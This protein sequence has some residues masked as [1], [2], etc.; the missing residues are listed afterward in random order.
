MGMT[1]E[2][3]DLEISKREKLIKDIDAATKAA[4]KAG[5]P[6]VNDEAATDRYIDLFTHLALLRDL[7]EIYFIDDEEGDSTEAIRDYAHSVGFRSTQGEVTTRDNLRIDLDYFPHAV[8]NSKICRE[9]KTVDQLKEILEGKE[10]ISKPKK[11][12][13]K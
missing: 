5:I 12:T 3:I 2:D 1:I 4:D 11:E 10:F 7:R 6:P 13:E 8:C 9:F